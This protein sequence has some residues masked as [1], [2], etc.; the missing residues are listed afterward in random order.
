MQSLC[1]CILE[2][3]TKVSQILV[4]KPYPSASCSRTN[5]KKWLKPDKSQI[6]T[7]SSKKKNIYSTW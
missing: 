6:Y 5:K 4:A 3:L 1:Y 7:N 2:N